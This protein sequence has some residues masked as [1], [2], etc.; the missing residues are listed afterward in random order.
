MVMET[1]REKI[2]MLGM[3]KKAQSVLIELEHRGLEP[4]KVE[5]TN[6]STI[7]WIEPPAENEF[8]TYAR[9]RRGDKGYGLAKHYGVTQLRDV[10]VQW[11]LA[12]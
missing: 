6:V 10:F 5:V 4:S 12:S 1:I 2:K 8:E 7:I 9:V 3:M 11:Q